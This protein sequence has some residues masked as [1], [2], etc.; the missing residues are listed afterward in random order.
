MLAGGEGGKTGQLPGH[1]LQVLPFVL[2][3]RDLEGNH[4]HPHWDAHL[5]SSQNASGATQHR[6]W[7]S[8]GELLEDTQH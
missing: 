7:A 4:G 5:F 2:A 3:A 8:P 6:Q 1:G